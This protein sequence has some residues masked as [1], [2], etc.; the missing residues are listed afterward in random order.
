MTPIRR[1]ASDTVVRRVPSYPFVTTGHCIKPVLLRS[2]ALSVRSIVGGVLGCCGDVGLWWFEDSRVIV[3]REG[4]TRKG[5]DCH[6]AAV[7][8]FDV[9]S[10]RTA[11]GMVV[12]RHVVGVATASDGPARR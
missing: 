11:G 3:A 10:R 6:D 9:A 7:H 2:V 1:G 12:R 8:C 4:L 5:G